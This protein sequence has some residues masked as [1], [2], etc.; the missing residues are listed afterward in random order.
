VVAREGRRQAADMTR[1]DRRALSSYPNF[2]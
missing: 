1:P 2:L